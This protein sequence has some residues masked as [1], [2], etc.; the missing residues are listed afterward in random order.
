MTKNKKRRA[1]W[2]LAVLRSSKCDPGLSGFVS[3]L[4]GLILTLA[5]WGWFPMRL[6]DWLSRREGLRNE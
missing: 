2:H 4:K 3:W 5:L 1:G 6:A